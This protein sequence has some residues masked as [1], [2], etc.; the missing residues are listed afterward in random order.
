MCVCVWPCPHCSPG[1]SNTNCPLCFLQRCLTPSVFWRCTCWRSSKPV[2]CVRK[3]TDSMQPVDT[4]MNFF[5]TCRTSQSVL[6]LP[7]FM[8]WPTKWSCSGDKFF[9]VND[10]WK[11]STLKPSLIKPVCR[12]ELVKTW[13]SV[14]CLFI[15]PS[16]T[17]PGYQDKRRKKGVGCWMVFTTVAVLPVN[18]LFV[19]VCHL[20]GACCQF[21]M[22]A[23]GS[24]AFS[25]LLG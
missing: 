20:T 11:S 3:I 22:G 16:L 19:K 4:L 1:V 15:R 12:M 5:L 25:Q 23:A 21:D 13:V 18:T 17:E 24:L 6:L 14:Q 9:C 10:P 2:T 7:V 8:Y